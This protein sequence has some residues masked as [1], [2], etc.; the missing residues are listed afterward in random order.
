M[1]DPTSPLHA[2]ATPTQRE[3]IHKPS[4]ASSNV[5]GMRGTSTCSFCS[6]SEPRSVTCVTSAWPRLSYMVSGDAP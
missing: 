2:S 4:L 1:A 6:S 5:C 3:W